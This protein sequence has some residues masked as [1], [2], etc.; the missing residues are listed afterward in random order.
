MKT[1]AIFF[2]LDG[3]LYFKGEAIEGA[4]ETVNQLRDKGYI[5]RFL[6]NTDGSTPKTI[7]DRLRNMGFNIQLEE[8]YTPITASI[9]F[10][11]R[12]EG[13][14]IYPLML[15]EVVDEYKNFNIGTEAV[16]YL[17]IGDCRDKI[18]YDHLNTV[19]RMIGENTEIFVTQKGRYFYN[20]DGKN[21]DT[22]AF[23]AMFEY[24]TGKVAKVLG[25]PSKDFFN[26]LLEDLNLEAG[27]VLIIGDDI[28]TD[29]VGANTI[30]AKGA[31]V[32]TGKYNDQRNLKV[33][34]PDMILDSV[35][36]L[37]KLL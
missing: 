29:I 31:L 25:K 18:S 33:A 35:V 30:G 5:C 3:T 4:I 21:I 36:D 9:K 23:A 13:A 7:L 28:T 34:E 6:T 12:I 15:D 26:I 20:A 19:F 16:D 24:A 32:K 27:Q 1:K 17:V 37:Q 22:G 2:D 10:L 8:I 11:E 14:R